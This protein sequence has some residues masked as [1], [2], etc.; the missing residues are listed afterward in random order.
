MKTRY[1]GQKWRLHSPQ[2]NLWAGLDKLLIVPCQVQEDPRIQVFDSRDN[3]E[4]KRRFYRAVTGIDW[5]V[6][7][8]P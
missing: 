4:F 3:Q 6:E 1:I 7:L 8:V 2:L 5:Q